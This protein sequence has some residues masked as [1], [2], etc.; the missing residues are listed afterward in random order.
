MENQEETINQMFGE[1]YKKKM[2]QSLAETE[3][4]DKEL[5]ELFF[6]LC[7]EINSSMITSLEL[8]ELIKVLPHNLCLLLINKQ[9]ILDKDELSAILR[10]VEYDEFVKDM[11]TFVRKDVSKFEVRFNSDLDQTGRILTCEEIECLINKVLKKSNIEDIS[12]KNTHYDY[13]GDNKYLKL[14]IKARKTLSKRNAS[15]AFKE[16]YFKR[17]KE[18]LRNL[19]T[20]MKKYNVGIEI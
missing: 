6:A 4:T 17:K 16:M 19:L 15:T 12:F 8:V 2:T 13:D 1:N 7:D 10:S 18:L 9:E 3:L 20:K 11:N 14:L 5:N